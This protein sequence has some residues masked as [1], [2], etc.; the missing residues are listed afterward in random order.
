M[1]VGRKYRVEVA[2]KIL[3]ALGDGETPDF[4]A[5]R[6]A[7][8]KWQD[9]VVKAKNDRIEK[10][11]QESRTIP[12]S[13]VF[14]QQ[15]EFVFG[16][17]FATVLPLIVAFENPGR[18]FCKVIPS[19]F[20]REM[21]RPIEELLVRWG[22]G[23]LLNAD[24]YGEFREAAR[25]PGF[26]ALLSKIEDRGRFEGDGGRPKGSKDTPGKSKR[27][28]THDE[29]A[30]TASRVRDVLTIRSTSGKIEVSEK[31]QTRE[32]LAKDAPDL[33]A[34]ADGWPGKKTKNEA[35]KIVGQYEGLKVA[36]V[37]AREQAATRP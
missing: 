6:M 2:D 16:E 26:S 18:F 9:D 36:G 19:I 24:A 10:A 7:V 17:T 3:Q 5:A 31:K 12:P 35:R 23:V 1:E 11:V 28:L 22:F 15:V 4:V 29:C 20:P 8:K 27:L 30:R 37:R 14:P 34:L 32:R 21:E 25:R 33:L 13:L